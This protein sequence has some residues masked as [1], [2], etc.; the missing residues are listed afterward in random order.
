[1]L[2][3]YSQIQQILVNF[4]EVPKLPS[5]DNK[6]LSI[7]GIICTLNTSLLKRPLNSYNVILFLYHSH[8][9]YI[10]TF[11]FSHFSINIYLL[12]S[13]HFSTVLIPKML[14]NRP[15][16][17]RVYLFQCLSLEVM[18]LYIPEPRTG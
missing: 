4:C 11:I 18:S 15:C 14:R 6:C 13:T 2:A 10:F 5:S 8:V 3:V 17:S 1:M 16:D 7:D 12:H 9:L